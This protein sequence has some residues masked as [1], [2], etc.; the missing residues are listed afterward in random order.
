MIWSIMLYLNHLGMRIPPKCLFCYLYTWHVS[1]LALEFLA[2]TSFG[3][4]ARSVGRTWRPTNWIWGWLLVW[5]QRQLRTT[6]R[7]CRLIDA[8][9]FSRL[10]LNMP[11]WDHRITFKSF[12]KSKIS[13]H[14]N[15]CK[16]FYLLECCQSGCSFGLISICCPARWLV[17]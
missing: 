14:N 13:V 3:S 10:A 7:V 15:L 2:G 9:G 17:I 6:Y 16:V 1:A 4:F 5:P 12:N 11:C 8:R